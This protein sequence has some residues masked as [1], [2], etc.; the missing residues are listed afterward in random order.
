MSEILKMLAPKFKVILGVGS[1]WVGG[2]AIFQ[3]L[4]LSSCQP[5]T[6]L[7]SNPTEHVLQVSLNRPKRL[8][9]MNKE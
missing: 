4:M 9:A 3:N 1:E 2:G 8:N 5:Q 7:L 6:L